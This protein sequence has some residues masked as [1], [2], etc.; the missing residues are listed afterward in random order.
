MPHDLGS[1]SEQP[2]TRTNAYNFQ[3]VSRWKDL[4]PKFVLQVYRDYQY[5]RSAGVRRQAEC[6]G[7]HQQATIAAAAV[8]FTSGMD[9]FLSELY[10]VLLVVMKST[11]LFDTDGD[12]MIENSGFPDQ[13]Y[14]IWT[15]RGVHA[16]CGGVRIVLFYI[17][18]QGCCVVIQF[19][20]FFSH[21]LL[22]IYRTYI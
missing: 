14:D 11:E 6:G 22:K 15:A 18:F 5:L 10:P 8:Q 3:D 2:W 17:C 12:G 21:L 20:T 4:G 7:H 16:Y 1:P 13:T 9:A 19:R